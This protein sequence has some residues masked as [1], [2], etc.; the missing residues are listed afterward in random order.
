MNSMINKEVKQKRKLAF[1]WFNLIV[2][3]NCDA[4]INKICYKI[5]TEKRPYYGL[6]VPRWE[7]SGNC[8]CE[9]LYQVLQ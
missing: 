7:I 8:S 2:D 5:A 4:H 1:F 3:K 6:I 9:N